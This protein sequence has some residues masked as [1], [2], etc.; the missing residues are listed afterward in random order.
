MAAT[1]E[2]DIPQHEAHENRDKMYIFTA[3]G[4]GLLTALEV[5][6]YAIPEAFGG[7]A[8]IT[9][10]MALMALMAIKFFTVAYVFMH[11]RF[12]KR[13]LTVVFYTGVGLALAVYLAILTMFRFWSHGSDHMVPQQ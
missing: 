3:L 5:L 7:K 11:L 8:S 4:L 2:Q 6:T 1:I 13:L 10:I 9:L 12:D